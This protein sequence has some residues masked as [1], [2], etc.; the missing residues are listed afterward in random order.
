[1]FGCLLKL[2]IKVAPTVIKGLVKVSMWKTRNVIGKR[3]NRKNVVASLDKISEI[4]S[5]I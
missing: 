3:K 1:M 5:H 4:S 2:N